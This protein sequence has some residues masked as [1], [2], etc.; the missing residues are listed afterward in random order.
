[1]AGDLMSEIHVTVPQALDG[2]TIPQLYAD[3]SAAMAGSA[4]AIILQGTEG[5]FS[6]GIDFEYLLRAGYKE[7]EPAVQTFMETLLLLRSGPKPVIAVIDGEARGSGVGLVAAADIAIATTGSEFGMPESLFGLSPALVMPFLEERITPQCA[8][9][10]AL[11][12]HAWTA[13]E[14]RSSG[15]IDRVVDATALRRET[16]NTARRFA[17]A[18]PGSVARIKGHGTVC[19]HDPLRRRVE[20]A[21]AEML[22]A[23]REPQVRDRILRFMVEGVAPWKLKG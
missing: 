1:M 23:M 4:G 15:L 6:R 13:E 14:A 5:L 18:N 10:L 16:R 3:V 9:L 20:M 19:G 21:A 12:A 11:I 8:R 7:F 22:E 17:L 2:E